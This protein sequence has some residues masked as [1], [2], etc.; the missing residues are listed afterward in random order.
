MEQIWQ[1]K[2]I[3]DALLYT[4]LQLMDILSLYK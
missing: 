4:L 3:V 1:L 2:M